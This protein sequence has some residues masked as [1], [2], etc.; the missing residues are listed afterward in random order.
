MIV[1]IALF[2]WKADQSPAAIASALDEVRQMKAKVA[3]II[4]IRCGENFSKWNEGFTHG[5]VVLAESREA[6]DQY[7]NHPDHAAV[8][9]LIDSMESKSI[10]VDFQD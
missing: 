3:G 2:A 10:G 1:H 6:L 5:V 8:G 9:R 4:E 7:R